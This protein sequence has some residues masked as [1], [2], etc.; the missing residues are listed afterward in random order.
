MITGDSHQQIIPPT[1]SRVK[2]GFVV[3][4][5]DSG[6][7]NIVILN[8]GELVAVDRK[9]GIRKV[10]FTMHPGDLV[11]VAALLEREKFQY[12]IEA[13]QDSTIT[14]V[15]E[16]CME[17]ELKTLPVWLLAVIKN[18]S[19]KTHRLKDSLHS[20]R[21]ENTLK[22][23]AEYCSHLKAK[24]TYPTAELIREFHWQTR[25][26]EAAIQ[27]DLK[28]LARREFISLQ[29]AGNDSEIRIASPLLLR[30]FTDYL[31]ATEHNVPWEPFQLSL[32]Q[33]KLLIKLA[34]AD[35]TQKKDAPDWIAY[36]KSKGL[37]IEVSE[38]I[39]MLRFGW[40]DAKSET[41]FATNTDKIKYYLAAL[42]FENNIK[43][44]L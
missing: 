28:A 18:L 30:I 21:C 23:L 33:K 24:T 20:A 35:H 40:L 37:D 44:A 2:A 17:S 26:P 39:R 5:P 4:S 41:Q 1:R 9:D 36:F 22:S 25:I 8:E 6:K 12:S 34:A 10:V 32:L 14:I 3:F 16:E 15:S 31:K 43:G 29:D 7:R 19:T 27:E 13:T 42:R 38:W 11:G